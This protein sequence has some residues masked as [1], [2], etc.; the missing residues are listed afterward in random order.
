MA[1]PFAPIQTTLP[2]NAVPKPS[3][4][5]GRPPT[6]DPGFDAPEP[7]V[8][9]PTVGQALEQPIPLNV[10]WTEPVHGSPRY[11]AIRPE[12]GMPELV[13]ANQSQIGVAL[14]RSTYQ[15][16]KELAAIA[17]APQDE[18]IDEETFRRL[19][20]PRA[21]PYRP[22][23]NANEAYWAIKQWD[24]EMVQSA[25]AQNGKDNAL[26]AFAGAFLPEMFLNPENVIMGLG[27][28][29]VSAAA[30]KA[31]AAGTWKASGATQALLQAGKHRDTWT[32]Y[33]VGN[34]MASAASVGVAAGVQKA[35]GYDYTVSD[36]A[37][38]F[39]V[40]MGLGAAIKFSVDRAGKASKAGEPTPEQVQQEKIR[41]LAVKL[42]EERARQ[43]QQAALKLTPEEVAAEVAT[44]SKLVENG[45]YEPVSPQDIRDAAEAINEAMKQPVDK[46]KPATRQLVDRAKVTADL[47]DSYTRPIGQTGESQ[48]KFTTKSGNPAIYESL[49][50]IGKTEDQNEFDSFVAFLR[51]LGVI[52]KNFQVE[53][54]AALMRMA[55]RFSA[56]VDK[57]YPEP[58]V[59]AD[60]M[61]R[62]PDDFIEH[63]LETR[64][65]DN[66]AGEPA[67]KPAGGGYRFKTGRDIAQLG[68][69]GA[70][71]VIDVPGFTIDGEQVPV[72]GQW[73]LHSAD[74]LIV[75][76]SWPGWGKVK[77]YPQELQQRFEAAKREIKL[78]QRVVEFAPSYLV[79][80]G[81]GPQVVN[82]DGVVVAGTGRDAL[83]R[84]IQ[85]QPDKTKW[86]KLLDVWRQKMDEVG[87]PRQALDDI[88][89]PRL[90]FEITTPLTKEQLVKLS[91][92]L[93]KQDIEVESTAERHY[94]NA[95][96]IDRNA[97]ADLYTGAGNTQ[98]ILN[99]T[100]NEAAI[101]KIIA[102][103][104]GDKKNFYSGGYVT[105]DG[106][107][108]ITDTLVAATFNSE[109]GKR[110]FQA[111]KNGGELGKRIESAIE[112]AIGKLATIEAM[113][114]TGRRDKGLSIADDIAKGVMLA[115]RRR[116]KQWADKTWDEF[117][118]QLDM[119]ETPSSIEIGRFISNNWGNGKALDGFF[120]GYADAVLMQPEPSKPGAMALFDVPTMPAKTKMQILKEISPALV[121][122]EV[123]DPVYVSPQ[124]QYETQAAV[125][126]AVAHLDAVPEGADAVPGLRESLEELKQVVRETPDMLRKCKL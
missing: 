79:D 24:E 114:G 108:E 122:D 9:P 76:H 60:A 43:A 83:M 116:S 42:A 26:T 90:V 50:H 22:G 52:D 87:I 99:A 56:Y 113:A 38:D 86:N 105:K 97:I 92:L 70:V 53:Q 107:R 17:Q 119:F 7:D 14:R 30:T 15:A 106:L 18:G 2:A 111:L 12:G 28:N 112:K 75:S 94:G 8:P 118:A 110:L 78:Q 71:D 66:L 40:G 109:D 96:N 82:R 1:E 80:R 6:R 126:A 84:A 85:S 33:L 27:F 93:N 57:N 115:L 48:K 36:A 46:G 45:T 74:D 51:Q 123:P 121:A 34:G 55:K 4:P 47:F 62:T 39:A 41:L 58:N 89:S 101:D 68:A 29:A 32:G 44:A 37:L 23:M 100:R 31:I 72:Q 25:L 67:A 125:D 63:A 124:L 98:D 77:E 81:S 103:M 11:M 59:D 10:Q 19:A 95:E 120:N 16:L 102:S 91:R 117:A 61:A 3:A 5:V 54:E 13:Y 69:R 88:Q 35:Y 49:Y 64:L 21:T 73:V 20:G 65:A 104:S